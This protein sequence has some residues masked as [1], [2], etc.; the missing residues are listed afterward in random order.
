MELFWGDVRKY[1]ANLNGDPNII[2]YDKFLE[3]MEAE[4][5]GGYD[6]AQTESFENT[7][8]LGMIIEDLIREVGEKTPR[9]GRILNLIKQKYTKGEVQ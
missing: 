8:L 1:I 3:G 6:H 7:T 5:E 9:Y 4:G 2:S